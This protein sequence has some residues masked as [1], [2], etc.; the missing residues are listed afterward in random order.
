MFLPPYDMCVMHNKEYQ[1]TKKHSP[2]KDYSRN[3]TNKKWILPFV[4][5]Q[6]NKQTKYLKNK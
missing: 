6:T 4:Q 2:Q 1:D 5:Q 3:L